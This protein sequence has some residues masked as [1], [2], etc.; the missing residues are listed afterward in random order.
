MQ[1]SLDHL[2]DE[3][4]LAQLAACCSDERRLKVRTL[5][6]LIAVEDRRL[7]L[8]AAASSMF[9]YCRRFLLMSH[10]RA[11]RCIAGARLCNQL[12][13]LLERI[14]SGELHVSTLA[15]IASFITP[16]NVTELIEETAGMNRSA[17]DL[18]LCR[19]FGVKPLRGRT[20]PNAL[21]MDED[22][23]KL[24]Q[25]A[26]ELLSHVVPDGDRLAIAKAAYTVLI[27]DL[28]KK[29]RGKADNPRPAP[30]KPTKEISR[31]ATRTM[32]EKHGEQCTFIDERTGARCPARVFI[33]RDHRV[34]RCR[35]GTHDA[36]DLRPMCGPHNRWLA[37]LAL[38]REYVEG[39]IRFRQQKQKNAK[40]PV[41]R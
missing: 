28:E 37:E 32:Y 35:G 13:F 2:S 10:G 16:E 7:Y 21:P 1:T 15:H 14:E 38:G 40:N 17:I 31:H 27:R 4:L 30:E 12:P 5:V 26:R 39:R 3:E 23:S 11:Y 36:K 18:V 6:S 22:L 9:D 29:T 25:R 41:D 24:E 8:A 34:L 33:Q 20:D 19:K